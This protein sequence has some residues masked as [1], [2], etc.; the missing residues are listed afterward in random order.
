MIRRVPTAMRVTAADKWALTVVL[1]LW[2]GM[3]ATAFGA[4]AIYG[5]NLPWVE[6]WEMV[7]ALTG[8]EPDLLQW[9]WAQIQEHRLPLQ[10]AIYLI[11]LQASGGDFRIGAITNAII[12]GGLTLALILTARDLRSRTR[13]ADAFFPLALLNLGYMTYFLFGF[14]IQFIIYTALI[15]IWLIIILRKPWPLSPNIAVISGLIS[16]LLPLAS[17]NGVLFAPFVALW[18]AAGTLLYHRNTTPR[19]IFPF[20]GTCVIISIAL[21]GLYFVGYIS[22]PW[23]PPHAAFGPTVVTGAR[24]VGMSL[25]PVGAGMGR[26]FPRSLIG[27]A[28]CG[29]GIL[30]WV[31]G[32]IP[33][34]HGFRYSRTPEGFRFFGVLLFASAMATL[35]LVMAWGRAG[36]V[37]QF[38][39]PDRYALLSVPALCAGYFAWLLYGPRTARNRAANAFAIAALL[40]LPFNVKKGIAWGDSYAAGM[41]AFEQDLAGGLSWQELGDKHEH[42]LSRGDG[43][44]LVDRMRML[45]EANIGP[46]GRATPP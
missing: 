30:L 39:M 31:S 19:W 20:Q 37:P 8:H 27:V 21:A 2:A 26:F 41:Q 22:P 13:L 14:Q 34:R 29:V 45:H 9:L 33:L 36:W 16:V 46:F 38:G 35:V 43:P 24:F 7:P 12:L 42:F 1:A 18:L 44:I 40:A 6:D 32:I 28:F 25:G 23:A 5:R 17:A 4:I 3:L 15:M 11:L 10:K